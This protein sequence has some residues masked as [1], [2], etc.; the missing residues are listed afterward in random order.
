MKSD[1]QMQLEERERR[2]AQ[3]MTLKCAFC[4]K[5]ALDDP[6]VEMWEYKGRFDGSGP[7]FRQHLTDRHPDIARLERRRVPTQSDRAEAARSRAAVI[8]A[9]HAAGE[10]LPD[11]APIAPADDPLLGS[12]TPEEPKEPIEERVAVEALDALADNLEAG[13]TAVEATIAAGDPEAHVDPETP[14]APAVSPPAR[15]QR[16]NARRGMGSSYTRDE[17]AELFIGYH[18]RHGRWPSVKECHADPE[19][20]SKSTVYRLFPKGWETAFSYAEGSLASP[21]PSVPVAPPCPS[22]TPDRAHAVASA[23]PKTTTPGEGMRALEEWL[24]LFPLD[25]V[26]HEIRVVE[27]A[28]G[29]LRDRGAALSAACELCERLAE[30]VR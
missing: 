21:P 27:Q 24:E 7:A 19:M 2:D 22:P 14:A 17:I 6:T 11:E 25:A 26:Q 16:K 20:P 3:E 13:T 30:L 23:A 10:A 9:A 8:A 15:A 1:E 28:V 18:A 5:A 29:H 4:A 12:S